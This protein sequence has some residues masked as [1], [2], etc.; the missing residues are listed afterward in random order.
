MTA[1][2]MDFDIP[3]LTLRTTLAVELMDLRRRHVGIELES[4]CSHF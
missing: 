1:A 2:L 3:H 4:C